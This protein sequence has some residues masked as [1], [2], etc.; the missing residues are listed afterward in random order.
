[1][2]ILLRFESCF[3]SCKFSQWKNSKVWLNLCLQHWT[4]NKI[5][6]VTW[7]CHLWATLVGQC[8]EATGEMP[9]VW[10]VLPL[11]EPT[12]NMSMLQSFWFPNICRQASNLTN[13][14]SVYLVDYST[15]FQNYG[16]Q[17]RHEVTSWTSWYLTKNTFV[18]SYRYSGLT[19][20]K[21]P[22][23][24]DELVI[25]SRAMLLS[26]EFSLQAD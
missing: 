19:P 2:F 9:G 17:I 8:V 20:Y 18:S 7:L 23:V 13:R 4:G 15:C 26:G 5:C 11:T 12:S 14:P 16:K 3:A 22:Q 21:L 1:M 24:K 25:S 6:S 10:R